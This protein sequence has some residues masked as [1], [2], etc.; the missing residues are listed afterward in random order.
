LS[1]ALSVKTSGGGMSS[2]AGALAEG[3]TAW[4]TAFMLA[5]VYFRKRLAEKFKRRWTRQV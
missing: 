1:A 3:E 5:P 4:A 2:N